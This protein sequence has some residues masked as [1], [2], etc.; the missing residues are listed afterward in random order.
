MDGKELVSGAAY[1]VYMDIKKRTNGEI[2]FGVVGPVRTGKS[3]FIKRFMELCV[4]PS[5]KDDNKRKRAQDELPQ[6]SGD[7]Y[8]RQVY[9]ACEG[10]VHSQQ[11]TAS[12]HFVLN[13]DNDK[14]E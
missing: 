7:V 10:E 3:T 13:Q 11:I 2:Y 14:L 8:K 12:C 4:L 9:M 5:M 6:S 1:D